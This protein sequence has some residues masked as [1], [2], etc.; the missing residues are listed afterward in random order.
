[1]DSGVPPPALLLPLPGPPF[2]QPSW[3]SETAVEQTLLPQPE[4]PSSQLKP[5]KM[6]SAL[7]LWSSPA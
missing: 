2:A 7:S 5:R 1:L 6:Q 3:S 4:A